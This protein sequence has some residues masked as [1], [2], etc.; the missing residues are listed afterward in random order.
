MTPLNCAAII[1]GI[2]DIYDIAKLLLAEE[3][4]LQVPNCA[5]KPHYAAHK[6]DV[7]LIRDLLANGADVSAVDVSQGMPLRYAIKHLQEKAAEVLLEAGVD[8][9]LHSQNWGMVLHSVAYCGYEKAMNLMLARITIQDINR[10][11]WTAL[12]MAAL[13]G[14]GNIVQ[15]LLEKGVSLSLL[16]AAGK[17]ALDLAIEYRRDKIAVMLRRY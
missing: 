9:T 1:S 5:T 3:V 14:Y 4:R 13:E 2:Y 17:I 10:A 15:L 16:N 6:G 7:G 12:H 11:K 8:G